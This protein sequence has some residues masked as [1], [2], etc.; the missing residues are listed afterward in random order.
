MKEIFRIHVFLKNIFEVQGNKGTAKMILFDGKVTSDVFTGII[1]PGAVD[2][3]IKIIGNQNKLSARY[4][5]NG[6]DSNKQKCQIFIQNEGID[7]ENGEFIKTTPFIL[8]NSEKLK[9]LEDSN[10]KGEVIGVKDG[11]IIRIYVDDY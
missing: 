1:L 3:Q 2:T 6:V 10:V 5:L 11:I 8:T 9:W 7:L 4:I